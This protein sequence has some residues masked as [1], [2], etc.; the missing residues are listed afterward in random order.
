[1]KWILAKA[2]CRAVTLGLFA[3]LLSAC[4][5]HSVKAPA[6][7]ALTCQ[8]E[9][10]SPGCAQALAALAA[11]TARQSAGNGWMMQGRAAISTGKQSGNTRVEWRQPAGDRYSVTLSAPIT[12]QSWRLDVAPGQST[13]TGLQGGPRT[14]SDAAM[15]LREATGW[16]IP[17]ASM[18]AWLRGVP[19]GGSRPSRYLFDAAGQLVGLEQ[20]GWRIDFTRPAAPGLP[21]GINAQRGDSRVRL[22]IDQWADDAR[23]V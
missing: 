14:G 21:T 11:E 18:G 1:M 19:A 6:T 17:V 12:R 2:P 8:A 22:V 16:D 10:S 7:A 13:I 15:L 5:G 3:L 20:D 23:T 9:G 4:A